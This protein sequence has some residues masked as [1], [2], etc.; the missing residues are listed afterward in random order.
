MS[1]PKSIKKIW[2]FEVSRDETGARKRR[3]SCPTQPGHLTA[4]VV[5]ESREL[6]ESQN[7]G[8]YGFRQTCE[9]IDIGASRM[10]EFYRL[11]EIS[12]DRMG[13]RY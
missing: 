13:T 11:F 6:S 12:C 10:V 1:M 4:I 3:L 2:L 7:F 8:F 5:H 9:K